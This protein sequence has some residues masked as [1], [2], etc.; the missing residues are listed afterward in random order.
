[1]EASEH[2]QA[3]KLDKKPRGSASGEEN[4]KAALAAVAGAVNTIKVLK[5][6]LILY[7]RC[8]VHNPKTPNRCDYSA[9]ALR[10][11]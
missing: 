1:M 2:R 11:L 5:P 6:L 7:Q 3:L 10:I 4:N 9:G 8:V